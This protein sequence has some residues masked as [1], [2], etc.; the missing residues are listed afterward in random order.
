MADLDLLCNDIAMIASEI[1]KQDPMINKKE[2]VEK[3]VEVYGND[4]LLIIA[5]SYIIN[6]IMENL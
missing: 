5:K 4:E 2:A 3:A 1:M 6:H